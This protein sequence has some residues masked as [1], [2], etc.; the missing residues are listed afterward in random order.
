MAFVYWFQK[1]FIVLPLLSFMLLV[2]TLYMFCGSDG[3]THNSLFL[4]TNSEIN[5]LKTILNILEE[6]ISSKVSKYVDVPK[7]QQR[8][9]KYINTTGMPTI[10]LITPTYTRYTQQADLIRMSNTLK[11]IANLHWILVE[12]SEIKTDLVASLLVESELP[13]THLNIKTQRDLQLGKNDPRWKKH[14]GVDQRNFAISWIRNNIDSKTKGVVYF[15]DDDNTYHQKLFDEMR[16]TLIVSIW[17]VALVGGLPWEG[18]VC[19]DG[20]VTHFYT[21]W[22]KS[23]QFP[24]DMAAFAINLELFF[25]Y[26]HAKINPESKR[27]YLETDFLQSLHVTL[28]DLEAKAK[29]CTKILIWH[30]Q[31]ADPKM[32]QELIL[33]KKGESSDMKIII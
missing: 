2:F 20:K 16:S 14:R 18:P 10:Y 22:E 33:N 8:L 7:L 30:T 21:S 12:D 5:N 3:D 32:K 1:K 17:P 4:K 28:D 6:R 26:P 31:T 24:V 19:K 23:R 15:A 29:D 9:Y 25:K 27:G 13:Y 11:L